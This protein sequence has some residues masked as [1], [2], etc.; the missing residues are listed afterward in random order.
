[1]SL[2]CRAKRHEGF[3]VPGLPLQSEHLAGAR[4]AED[5]DVKQAKVVQVLDRSEQRQNLVAAHQRLFDRHGQWQR[6]VFGGVLHH[7]FLLSCQVQ[8]GPHIGESLVDDRLRVFLGKL[9]Q[10]DLNLKGAQ[11]A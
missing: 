7:I 11:L 5:T 1:M 8:N 10:V 4:A 2:V 6:H 3:P 9:V